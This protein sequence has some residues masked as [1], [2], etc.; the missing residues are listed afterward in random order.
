M[1]WLERWRRPGIEPWAW[2][3]AVERLGSVHHLGRA[4]LER[5]RALAQRFLVRKAVT[6]AGGLEVDAEMR[7][8]IA[9]QAALLV[10]NLDLSYYGTFHQVIVYP[11]TF[12][13]EHEETDEAGVVHRIRRPL[14]GEAWHQGP[15]I[16]SWADARPGVPRPPGH[17]VVIHEFAHKLDM[18]G[19]AANG[20]PPLH[21]GVD[22]SAWTRDFTAAWE[23]FQ[24]EGDGEQWAW[25]DPYALDSPAEFFSVASEY[26]FEAPALLQE[27]LP[28]I[29]GHLKEFYR[30]DPAAGRAG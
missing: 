2:T 14:S 12:L 25:L 4:D 22:P 30:Q 5:L 26:F 23:R 17:N 8:V 13:V 6:G 10:L 20:R 28:A 21:G 24:H 16:L 18:A 9:A 19:G 1:T 29:Y 15:V 27:H 11:G 3:G 7:A